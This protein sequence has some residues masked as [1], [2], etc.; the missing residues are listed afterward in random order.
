MLTIQ[1]NQEQ[2]TKET[3]RILVK[4]D[5]SIV[6]TR[7]VKNKTIVIKQSTEISQ[8]ENEFKLL[9]MLN[10][11]NIIKCISYNEPELSLEYCK[12]GDLLTA[13]MTQDI[14]LNFK[15]KMFLEVANAIKYLHSLNI[16]HRFCFLI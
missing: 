10:H 6:F 5:F 1:E 12:G 3:K 8:L 7:K 9:S 15:K 4:S 14:E 11:I 13:L 16:V 2:E